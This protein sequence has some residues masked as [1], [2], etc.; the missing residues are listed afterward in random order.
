MFAENK[1]MWSG[2]FNGDFMPQKSLVTID[3]GVKNIAIG[4]GLGFDSRAGQI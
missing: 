2:E 4:A 1:K 3:L